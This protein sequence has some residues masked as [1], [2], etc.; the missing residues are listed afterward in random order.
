MHDIYTKI[1]K[2]L[3]NNLVHYRIVKHAMEG[4][5]KEISKIRGNDPFQAMKALV[6][7]AK[8]GGG[9]KR[10][11]L[12]VIPGCLRLDMKSLN[13]AIGSQKGRFASKNKA[14]M[15]TGCV[16]GAIPPF[17]FNEELKLIVDNKC[18]ENEEIVFNAGRLDR[19]IFMSFKE[20]KKLSRAQFFHISQKEL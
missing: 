12:A 13:K 8:G 18:E 7:D 16:S 6:I 19:S 17:S 20:Y 11:I 9:G 10:S 14:L 15:L 4:R 5:S 3:D 1:I 2:L